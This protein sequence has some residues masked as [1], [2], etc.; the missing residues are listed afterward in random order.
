MEVK[1]RFLQK[2]CGLILSNI[3]APLENGGEVTRGGRG[4]SGFQAG[5]GARF[6]L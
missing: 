2:K 3:E 1:P 5:L 6:G 4:F